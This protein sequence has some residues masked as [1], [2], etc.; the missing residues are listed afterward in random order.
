M[1]PELS[2]V[3]ALQ[4]QVFTQSI[5]E[6]GPSVAVNELSAYQNEQIEV[7]LYRDRIV[8]RSAE[9]FALSRHRERLQ[10][11]TKRH[12]YADYDSET[13]LP[14]LWCSTNDRY[15]LCLYENR[16]ADEQYMLALDPSLIE[17]TPMIHLY[18]KDARNGLH[19]EKIADWDE[20]DMLEY[21]EKQ[22]LFYAKEERVMDEAAF[23]KWCAL[24]NADAIQR[25]MKDMRLLNERPMERHTEW[26]L[27]MPSPN[28]RFYNGGGV[29]VDNHTFDA[30]DVYYGG[31]GTRPVSLV[32]Y[33]GRYRCLLK[34]EKTCQRHCHHRG[35][36]DLFSVLRV[37][38]QFPLV[39]GEKSG[40]DKQQDPMRTNVDLS[41]LAN[42]L[43]KV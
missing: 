22:Q 21:K 23:D 4:D 2:P 31:H 39:Y 34:C 33:S 29:S 28:L 3:I 42:F 7:T 30:A 8:L 12:Y 25:L 26:T 38:N 13:R 37:P 6:L 11:N 5:T 32:P 43:D 40:A 24:G 36:T 20:R 14:A 35:T 19:I 9:P 15:A 17:R 16:W 41:G 27:V 1:E 10:V 18:H